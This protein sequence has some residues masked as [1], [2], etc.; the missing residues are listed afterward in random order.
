VALSKTESNLIVRNKGIRM[1]I[2][3]MTLIEEMIEKSIGNF[4]SETKVSCKCSETMSE[5]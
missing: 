1:A 2:P 5:L 4:D 3:L